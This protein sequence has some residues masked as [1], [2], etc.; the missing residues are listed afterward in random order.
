MGAI[1]LSKSNDYRHFLPL[2]PLDFQVLT[3]LATQELH[4][5]GIVQT[6]KAQFPDQ[7]ALELGSLYRII[8]RML[9]QELIREVGPPATCPADRRTRRYYTITELGLHV[10][11]AE[12]ARMRSLLAAPVT[13]RLEV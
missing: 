10:I 9:D 1:V 2:K 7:P 11:R 8:N 12:A 3:V 13:R 5:Y 4:G 6:T